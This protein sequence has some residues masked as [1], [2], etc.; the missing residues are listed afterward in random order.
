MASTKERPTIPEPSPRLLEPSCWRPNSRGSYGLQ[1]LDRLNYRSWSVL[2]TDIK[3]NEPKR[4]MRKF[5]FLGAIMLVI[6]FGF[7]VL[8]FH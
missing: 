1:D 5:P 7:V 8:F 6:I 4:S 3:S 2:S